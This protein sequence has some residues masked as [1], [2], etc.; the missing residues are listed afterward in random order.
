MNHP[1]TWNITQLISNQKYIVLGM[2]KIALILAELQAT[3]A[4][5]SS[6]GLMQERVNG[7]MCNR[8]VDCVSRPLIGWLTS[9]WGSLS[10]Q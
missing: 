7:L 8:V 1:E 9:N 3:G 2:V 10:D 6:E 5:G 4:R